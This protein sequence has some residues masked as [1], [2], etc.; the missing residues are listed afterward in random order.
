MENLP[1]T[2]P[3]DNVLLRGMWNFKRKFKSD[4]S[5][6]NKVYFIT[7]ISAL[8]MLIVITLFKGVNPN[9]S[10]DKLNSSKSIGDYEMALTSRGYNPDKDLLVM[11]YKVSSQGTN[12]ALPLMKFKVKAYAGDEKLGLKVYRTDDDQY[13]VI[14]N[15][16]SSG[17]KALTTHVSYLNPNATSSTDTDFVVGEDSIT[18]NHLS[19]L[20]PRDYTVQAVKAEINRNDNSIKSSQDKISQIKTTI[21]QNEDSI[22]NYKASE[23]YKINHDKS[24]VNQKIQDLQSQ[25]EQNQKQVDSLNKSIQRNKDRNTLLQKELNDIKNGMFDFGTKVISQNK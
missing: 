5:F 13:T 25:N 21:S 10:Y 16:L 6:K 23:D 3:P 2:M 15:G 8:L 4:T 12:A 7:I 19:E 9:I 24:A 17:Y 11:Q 22:D 1:Q 20:Q 14:V 18:N